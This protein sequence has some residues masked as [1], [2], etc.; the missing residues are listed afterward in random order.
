MDRISIIIR[1][2]NEAE[3]I[4]F[5]IQSCL[6]HF[7]KPQII[8]MDN[9]SKDDSLQVVNLFS[10]R[11][12]IEIDTIVDYTPGRAINRAVDKCKHDVVLVLSAHCQITEMKL[13]SVKENLSKYKAIFGKQTPIY[14]GKKIS[15][16]YIWSHFTPFETVNMYSAIEDRYFFHNAF[17]FYDKKFLLANPMPEDVP[18][19]EDRFWAKSIVDKGYQYLYDPKLE[20][21]HFFTNNGATWHGIG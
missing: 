13:W 15:R 5:A 7:D 14:R 16:R 3:F 9:Q 6:D 19:K 20:V 11:T 1:N 12:S 18:G 8:V 17:T 21:N 4:G 2:R 10:D